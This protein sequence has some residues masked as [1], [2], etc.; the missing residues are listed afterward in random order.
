LISPQLQGAGCEAP[1][2]KRGFALA[3]G[4]RHPQLLLNFGI[5]PIL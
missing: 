2:A 4:L 3:S 5:Y 1:L